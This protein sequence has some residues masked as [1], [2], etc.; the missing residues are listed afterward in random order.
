[1]CYRRPTTTM[2]TTTS[3]STITTHQR[4][5]CV[6]TKAPIRAQT[7]VFFVAL[8]RWQ[9]CV[10][11]CVCYCVCWCMLVCVCVRRAEHEPSDI[12][13]RRECQ[14][15]IG[16][17]V[18]CVY[19]PFGN[20]ELIRALRTHS[21]HT[22]SRK[23]IS[24]SSHHGEYNV[25]YLSQ[26]ANMFVAAENASCVVVMV[27]PRSTRIEIFEHCNFPRQRDWS[28][29]DHRFVDD[30]LC[31]VSSALVCRLLDGSVWMHVWWLSEEDSPPSNV[32]LLHRRL[33]E[34]A[35]D[36][37]F[38]IDPSIWQTAIFANPES[39]LPTSF[40]CSSSAT[41]AVQFQSNRIEI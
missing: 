24:I 32:A 40:L 15:S 2:T 31:F 26:T 12:C 27:F 39:D 4:Q 19:E 6:Y 34:G 7:S 35:I 5:N 36:S 18:R 21:Q 8:S 1:M 20:V 23:C 29:D 16:E 25:V 28:F 33:K 13:V 17:Y 37:F 22:F 14:H 9:V 3:M 30:D 11:V 41:H 38:T 10:C